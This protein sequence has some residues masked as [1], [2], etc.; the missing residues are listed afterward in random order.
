MNDTKAI[1]VAVTG[2]DASEVLERIVHMEELGIP[3]AW[4]TSGGAGRD[5]LTMFAAAAARTEQILLGTSIVPT[6]PRHPVVVATQAR[7]LAELAPGRF[8]LGV[9]PSHRVGTERTFGY[10][11][12]APLGHLREYLRILKALIQQGQV[13]FEGDYYTARAQSGASLDVPVMASAL[14]QR[15]FELCGA[16]ADGAITWV[17]PGQY[18]RD[19]AVPAM[20][21]GATQAGREVPPLIAHAPVCVHDDVDE[22]RAAVREQ[23]SN[24][25]ASPFYQQMF[26]EAGFPE[27]LETSEWSD[28]MMDA[29]VLSGDESTV[30]ERLM[31]M[32][33]YGATELVLS[34][35]LVGS[36]RNA[37]LERTL[38]L[39]A[40]AAQ[41]RQRGRIR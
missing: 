32:F 21:A 6:W 41:G 38:R 12:Q 4:L 11:F 19:V 10:D 20:W 35:V 37:S 1:G 34:P 27:A 33:A 23:M 2:R 13:E 9:G 18:V 5:S 24:Y 29:V 36:D 22:M 16:E 31:E 28:T 39:V 15:S 3:A 8:R 40:E 25:P 30:R 17:C 7:V 26:A 14:R